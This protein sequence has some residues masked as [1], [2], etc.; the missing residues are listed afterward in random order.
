MP[1]L[2]FQ[3]TTILMLTT[4]LAAIPAHA[5][6]AELLLKKGVITTEEYQQL[7]NESAAAG[8][9]TPASTARS[10]RNSAR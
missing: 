9:P 4:S 10:M 6:I 2:E 7:K 8:A 5:G 1:L 3:F